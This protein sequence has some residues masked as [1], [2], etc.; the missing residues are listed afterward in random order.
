MDYLTYLL[1]AFVYLKNEAVSERQLEH[2]IK[3]Y[4]TVEFSKKDNGE[5]RRYFEDLIKLEPSN[6]WAA[7]IS[8]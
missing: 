5:R 6:L 4:N 2:M 1:G 7:S 8:S 3:W